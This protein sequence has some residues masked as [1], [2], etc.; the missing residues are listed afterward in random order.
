ML[1]GCIFWQ[2]NY[3][4]FCNANLERYSRFDVYI[5]ACILLCKL[6]LPEMY[7]LYFT[8]TSFVSFNMSY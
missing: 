2:V 6:N 1:T 4:A 8:N 3:V 5:Y 7:F